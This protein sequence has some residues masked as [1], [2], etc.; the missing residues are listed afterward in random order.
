MKKIKIFE[1]SLKSSGFRKLS[2]SEKKKTFKRL[3][4][5]FPDRVTS[6]HH[7]QD[8]YVFEHDAYRVVINSGIVDNQLLKPGLSW[9]MITADDKRLFSRPFLSKETKPSQI[10]LDRILAYG[11]VARNIII[12]RPLAKSTNKLKDLIEKEEIIINDDGDPKRILT[13]CW[14]SE[15]EPEEYV[16]KPT[17][18]MEYLKNIPKF[19]KIL[20]LKKEYMLQKYFATRT[21]KKFRKEIR[22]KSKVT[23]PENRIS[24]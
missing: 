1:K 8:M 16:F 20:F 6:G 12:N 13:S 3:G 19:F 15:G 2:R 11:L 7:L 24:A 5:Q 18:Q 14:V 10:M 4:L 21:A 22:K 17:N 23:K 9:V